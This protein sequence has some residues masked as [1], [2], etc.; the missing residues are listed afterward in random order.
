[1]SDPPSHM[2]DEYPKINSLWKRDERGR[3]IIG[4]YSQSEYEFLAELPWE[5]TEKVDGTNIRLGWAPWTGDLTVELIRGRT[6]NAQLPPH[7]LTRLVEIH[8]S[9]PW[10]DV[11]E[12]GSALEHDPNKHV[13]L[14][15]EGYGAK[16]QK[17]GGNYLPDRCDFVLFDVKVGRWWLRRPDVEDVARKLGVDAVP[18]VGTMTIPEAVELVRSD[19]FV[20]QWRNA[21]P[22]GLV[23]RPLVDLFDRRGERITT[24]VKARDLR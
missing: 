1:M 24:K 19:G 6:D 22:E 23:G 16:I 17:G 2:L 13:T 21:S 10:R 8:T 3:V 5:W 14:Y 11:F 12:D 15:G 7:L 9:L 20:S 18:V 4:D